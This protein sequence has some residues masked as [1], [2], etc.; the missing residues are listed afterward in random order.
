MR[1]APLANAHWVV[2]RGLAST[3]TGALLIAVLLALGA[4]EARAQNDAGAKT[5]DPPGFLN[6]PLEDL[7]DIDVQE[8]G[9]LGTHTHLVGEW[10]IGY[11][12]MSMLM[13]GN[14]DGTTRRSL[15][16]VLQQF[17]VAPT[18]MRMEMHMLDIMY[19]P[20]DTLT[21]M[22]MVPYTKLSMDHRTR[23]GTSFTTATAGLGDLGFTALYSVVGNV[24]R[25]RQRL[26]I[27]A[28][29]TVPSGSI[30]ERGRTPAGADQKLPYPMQL[31]SGTYDLHPG[32]SY[33][34][35]FDRWAWT[36]EGSGT[37]RLGTN[38]NAYRLG[39][40]WHVAA[41]A[42]R[43]L[44]RWAGPYVRFEADGW[45]NIHGADP[46]LNP[47]MVP[48]ADPTLRGGSRAVVASGLEFYVPD[49]TLAGNR[50]AVEVGFPVHQSLRGP[51]LETD[52]TLWSGWSL[53]F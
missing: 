31:G 41:S 19:A 11:K 28:G 52:L 48:T 29:V 24:R 14:R 4:S 25:D 5:D 51:Q 20:T 49:G 22:A 33:L 39:N 47:M 23:M 30:D 42:N 13:S 32:L 53:T 37:V 15:D 43:R 26:V 18:S 8:I 38:H 44:T 10:M 36:V 21:L 3:I 27:R 50:L 12:V 46:D 40:R 1:H 7:L 2:T 17:M 35:E 45:G 16:N 34:A 6:L 9:V